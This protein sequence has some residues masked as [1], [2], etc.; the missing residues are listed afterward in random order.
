LNEIKWR[1]LF[2]GV[3]LAIAY[4]LILNIFNFNIAI[5]S[6]VF[7]LTLVIIFHTYWL[8]QLDLW[9]DNPTIKNLPN[10]SGIWNKIFSKIYRT[11]T[12]QKK[13]KQ[14]LFEVLDLFKSGAGAMLDGVVAVNKNNEILWSNK[15][16]QRML[17]IIPK[18]D[19]NRPIFY[20]YR[21]T[22]FKAY[23]ENENYEDTLK[24]NNQTSM[25]PLE[26]KVAYFG[27]KQRIIVFRD[28]TKET[29]IQNMRKE[30]VSNFSHEIKTPLTV[31]I[32]FIE[33]L[34]EMKSSKSV[35]EKKIISMMS[36][37]ANRMNILIED[38]LL[39]SHIESNQHVNRSEKINI[40][41]LIRDIKKNV[42]EVK[43]NGHKFD[44]SIDSKLD[45]YGARQ[46][47]ESAFNNLIT[48]AI[49]YTPS[50]GQISIR[51]NLINTLP[52]FEVVDNG[53]GIP[54]K[55][56]KRISE[57]FYRV[58]PNRSRE[59]GGTGLGLAIVKN[60]VNQHQGE[61]KINSDIGLGS[62][63]KLIFP[64]DRAIK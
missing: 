5:L 6:L 56:I 43:G 50:K 16:A 29:E 34:A 13:T 22:Y 4:L 53:I 58:D 42:I 8:Y 64:A 7:T 45:L 23:I 51:W 20:I 30:F 27:S 21:N 1:A 33:T 28:I 57:R 31:L 24:I 2:F 3:I 47:I 38:L 63:F 39:L 48:N 40:A 61:M 44:F 55:N 10:G 12:K 26:I 59:T 49:R 60:V 18:N 9:L 41:K 52:I 32:G 11:E 46:E 15:T 62:S 37:Q 14:E 35:S 36:G 19:Y 54:E 25:P 17:N